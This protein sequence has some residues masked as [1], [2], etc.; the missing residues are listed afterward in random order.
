MISDC[1]RL[2]LSPFLSLHWACLSRVRSQLH[3]R[4]VSSEHPLLALIPLVLRIDRYCK[5]YLPVNVPFDAIS[6]RSP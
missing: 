1:L 6:W 4:E 5:L 3:L 2:L